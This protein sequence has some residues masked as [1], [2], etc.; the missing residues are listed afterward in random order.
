MRAHL[1][2]SRALRLHELS[3]RGALLEL[4]AGA[5]IL[6]HITAS[7]SRALLTVTTRLTPHSL[8]FGKALQHIRTWV[9]PASCSSAA[10]AAAA[11]ADAAAATGRSSSLP[12]PDCQPA[13]CV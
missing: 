9:R 3:A 7:I 11:T 4:P 1:S 8:G 12:P 2:V 10:A 5:P 13:S 6:S